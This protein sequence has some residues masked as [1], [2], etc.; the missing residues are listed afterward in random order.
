MGCNGTRIPWEE[1]NERAC[2][3]LN[4]AVMKGNPVTVVFAY[5]FK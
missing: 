2:R 5:R 4:G 3:R 1:E